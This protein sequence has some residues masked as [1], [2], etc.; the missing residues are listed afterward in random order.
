MTGRGPVRVTLDEDVRALPADELTFSGQAGTPVLA[1]GI[2]VELK[3][4]GA[5]P[6]EFLALVEQFALVPRPA[7]KYR[8]SVVALGY[9]PPSALRSV[10][11][12]A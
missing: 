9:A 5:M 8:L 6:H 3:Y 12:T 2:I 1:A 10:V 4:S 7:S 11:E